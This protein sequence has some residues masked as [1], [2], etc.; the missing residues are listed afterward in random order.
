MRKI[1]ED[2]GNRRSTPSPEATA[3]ALKGKQPNPR[4]YGVELIRQP[5]ATFSATVLE[6]KPVVSLQVLERM[7]RPR[8]RS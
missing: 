2:R 1:R 4:R 7:A 8:R 3:T 6:S 5:P